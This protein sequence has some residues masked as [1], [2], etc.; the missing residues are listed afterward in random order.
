MC[1]LIGIIVFTHEMKQKLENIF[2]VWKVASTQTT[3]I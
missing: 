1:M 2:L 3:L